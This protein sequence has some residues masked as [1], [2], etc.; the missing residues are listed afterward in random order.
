MCFFSKQNHIQ[1][2]HLFNVSLCKTSFTN[3]ITA[4]VQKYEYTRW[5]NITATFQKHH[6]N[7]LQRKVRHRLNRWVY[8]GNSFKAFWEWTKE[9]IANI[10]IHNVQNMYKMFKTGL[11]GTHLVKVEGVS[12]MSDLNHVGTQ[13]VL[14]FLCNKS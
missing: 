4:V 5:H 3:Q 6:K 9:R 10:N 1:M 8:I 12:G 11:V 14:C 2:H 13:S 7:V